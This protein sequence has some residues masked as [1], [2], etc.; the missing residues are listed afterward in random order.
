MELDPRPVA[1]H[2][3]GDGPAQIDLQARHAARRGG[4]SQARTR[5]AAAMQHA[6]GADLV[7]RR[8]PG[9]EGG[10]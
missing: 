4:A 1:Q 3:G 9:G 10:Q 5:H 6:G 8:G 7:E 2:G